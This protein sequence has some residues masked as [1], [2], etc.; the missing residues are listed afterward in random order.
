MMQVVVHQQQTAN[1][2]RFFIHLCYLNS[3]DA[4]L[5]ADVAGGGYAAQ[6]KAQLLQTLLRMGSEV[7]TS[8]LLEF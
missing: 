4:G 2:P 1:G 6:F 7:D 8:E 5:G 3:T